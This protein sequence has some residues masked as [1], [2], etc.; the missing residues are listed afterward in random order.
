VRALNIYSIFLGL[1]TLLLERGS[2][3]DVPRS[4]RGVLLVNTFSI[5]VCK[6]INAI[7]CLGHHGMF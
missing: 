4:A 7:Y 5:C 2:F 3:D 1:I 6:R